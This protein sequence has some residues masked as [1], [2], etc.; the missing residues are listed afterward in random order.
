MGLRDNLNRKPSIFPLKKRGFHWQLF[1]T[2]GPRSLLAKHHQ[3]VPHCNGAVAWPRPRRTRDPFERSLLRRGWWWCRTTPR[4]MA[5]TAEK[6]WENLG[7][8]GCCGLFHVIAPYFLIFDGI[9]AWMCLKLWM[10]WRLGEND[11]KRWDFKVLYPILRQT[12]TMWVFH[13]LSRL[14]SEKLLEIWLQ[15]S[16]VVSQF[17]ALKIFS[18]T[19]FCLSIPMTDPWCW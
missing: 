6:V 1:V 8:N 16:A 17:L 9:H 19:S 10:E 14:D 12:W 4:R 5:G 11:D 3:L 2:S 13:S 18:E 7:K 15:I